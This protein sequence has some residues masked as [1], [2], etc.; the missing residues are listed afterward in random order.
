MIESRLDPEPDPRDSPDTPED[1]EVDT[2]H[3]P[4]G[5][6]EGLPDVPLKPTPG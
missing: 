2:L 5:D 3:T 4:E 6:G 1:D